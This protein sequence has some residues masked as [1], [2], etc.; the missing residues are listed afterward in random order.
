MISSIGKVPLSDPNKASTNTLQD[1]LLTRGSQCRESSVIG[2][3]Q[4]DEAGIIV[5]NQFCF[6]ITQYDL[7]T[8]LNED[9][10]LGNIINVV[11]LC[12]AVDESNYN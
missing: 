1:V 9:N 7:V 12:P 11:V 6:P 3:K 8:D 4:R 5:G 2:Q 10:S